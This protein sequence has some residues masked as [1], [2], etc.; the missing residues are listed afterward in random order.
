MPIEADI[1]GEQKASVADA[2][3][4]VATSRSPV[5]PATSRSALLSCCMAEADGEGLLDRRRNCG[6]NGF[7]LFYMPE[8]EVVRIIVVGQPT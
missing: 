1:V 6:R 7:P 2:D 4:P 8:I 5:P 3:G